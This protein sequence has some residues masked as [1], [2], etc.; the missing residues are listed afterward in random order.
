VKKAGR[1]KGLTKEVL[2]EK[3]FGWTMGTK[4]PITQPEPKMLTVSAKAFKLP[5]NPFLPKKKPTAKETA[6]KVIAYYQ[7][8]PIPASLSPELRERMTYIRGKAKFIESY[9]RSNMPVPSSWIDE[10]EWVGDGRVYV[11]FNGNWYTYSHIKESV[12]KRWQAGLASC[13]T[14]DPQGGSKMHRKRWIK[15]KT[16]SLGAFYNRYIKGGYACSRGKH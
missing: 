6:M 13:I 5:Q 9:L 16:P 8:K 3:H 15:G 10:L 1:P 7:H 4:F 2:Y 14:D 11:S 12:F